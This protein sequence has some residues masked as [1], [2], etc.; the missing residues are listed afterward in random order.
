MHDK[1][2]ELMRLHALPEL[3]ILVNVWD[4]ASA[5][6]VAAQPGCRAIATASAA[7]AAAHGYPDG[8]RIPPRLMF[9]MID[10]IAAAVDL[11]V[12]A[13]LEAGYGDPA[14]AVRAAIAAG[15]VGA[16]LEDRMRP[17]ADAVEAVQSAVTAADA[18]GVPFVLN[19]RTD[20]FLM[21]AGREPDA[22]LADAMQRGKAFLDA[23]ASCVFVPG[24][25]DAQAIGAL[26]DALGRGRLSVLAMPRTPPPDELAALG[27]ARLSYGPLPQRLMSAALGDLA[28]TLLAGS[29]LPA[30]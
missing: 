29:T 4:V 28:A 9:E 27:V 16:N 14:A 6:A 20:A 24:V 8:E 17:L 25:L 2:A 30:S 22:V 7:I 5:R 12:T 21:A 19:A 10:R 13:D 23:G 3:L 1:A 11:P 15:V 18:E 26:V